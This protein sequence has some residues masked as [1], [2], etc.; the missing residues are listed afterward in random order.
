MDYSGEYIDTDGGNYTTV[1]VDPD[2]IMD[3]LTRCI[4]RL[5]DRI[6]KLEAELKEAKDKAYRDNEMKR[7]SESLEEA[8]E[9]LHRGFPITKDEFDDI[10]RWERRWIEST[11]RRG[12]HFN[13]IFCPTELGIWGVVEAPDGERFT[14]R[15]IG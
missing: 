14:F 5:K 1:R 11:G 13:Y 4:S 3:E 9:M 10:K 15:D 6:E 7:M 2:K 12:C 8:K